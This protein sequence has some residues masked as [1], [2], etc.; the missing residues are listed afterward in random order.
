MGSGLCKMSVSV[1]SFSTL[2][3]IGTL[4]NPLLSLHPFK[5][6]SLLMRMKMSSCQCMVTSPSPAWKIVVYPASDNLQTDK[7]ELSRSSGSMSSSR[8]LPLSLLFGRSPFSDVFD[9]VPVGMETILLEG[10]YVLMW[11]SMFRQKLEVAAESNT[12]DSFLFRLFSSLR[13]HFSATLFTFSR[14]SL[15]PLSNCSFLSVGF[16]HETGLESG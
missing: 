10:L 2:S 16:A 4:H 9:L 15:R 6:A 11:S 8:A 5:T 12:A 1:F 14:I 13:A 3:F 7:S